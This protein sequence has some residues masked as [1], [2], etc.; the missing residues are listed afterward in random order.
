MHTPSHIRK[1]DVSFANVQSDQ[2]SNTKCTGAGCHW[3]FTVRECEHKERP[4]SSRSRS[5]SIALDVYALPHHKR[6]GRQL[7][8]RNI[9]VYDFDAG[10]SD[11][12][13]LGSFSR[14][15]T[16]SHTLGRTYFSVRFAHQLQPSGCILS[17]AYSDMLK[18]I[19]AQSVKC[20]HARAFA[21][22]TFRE[23]IAELGELRTGRQ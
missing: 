23:I 4:P 9:S 2:Q 21:I 11:T 15:H 14:A 16:H 19:A 12:L 7:H 8:R 22:R 20:E 17:G 3:S 5:W 6:C 1:A 18:K 10:S 13:A